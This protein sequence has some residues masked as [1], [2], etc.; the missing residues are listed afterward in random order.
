MPSNDMRH[1]NN[2]LPERPWGR[3]SL[4]TFFIPQI[5][6]FPDDEDRS[7]NVEFVDDDD[8]DHHHHRRHLIVAPS[9][10]KKP[11]TNS[12]TQPSQPPSSCASENSSSNE[13]NS[14][15]EPDNTHQAKKEKLLRNTLLEPNTEGGCALMGTGIGSDQDTRRSVASR[16]LSNMED[17]EVKFRGHRDSVALARSRI[18]AGGSVLPEL[19]MHQGSVSVT[20]KQMH[21][22]NPAISYG[23]DV[24]R[25]NL[26]ASQLLA[27]VDEPISSHREQSPQ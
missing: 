8:D 21:V 13:E 3:G 1:A 25:L 7:S 23:Q 16:R 14:D 4:T 10:S 6:V 22:R 26:A 18:F 9:D 15:A 12:S 2:S 19:F 24:Y 5:V 20:K 27:T 11:S 17:D